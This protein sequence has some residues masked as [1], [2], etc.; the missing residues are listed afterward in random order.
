MR[1]AP[2]LSHAKAVMRSQLVRH[3]DAKRRALTLALEQ[4]RQALQS[5]ES[6]YIAPLVLA[7]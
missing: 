5:G 7:A 3:I 4:R 1:I 6:G 2:S